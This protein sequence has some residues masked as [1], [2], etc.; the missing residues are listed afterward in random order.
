MHPEISADVTTIVRRSIGVAVPADMTLSCL[1]AD[2]NLRLDIVD[3]VFIVNVK[4]RIFDIRPDRAP[5]TWKITTSVRSVAKTRPTIV[6]RVV[7]FV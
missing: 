5:R 3:I 6:V 7:G 4:L 2:R 1:V